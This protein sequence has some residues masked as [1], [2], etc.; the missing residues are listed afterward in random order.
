[1]ARGVLEFSFAR[2]AAGLGGNSAKNANFAKRRGFCGW[3]WIPTFLRR[4]GYRPQR[5]IGLTSTIRGKAAK[6]HFGRR[7]L[8]TKSEGATMKLRGWKPPLAAIALFAAACSSLWTV[9]GAVVGGTLGSLGGPLTAGLGAGAGAAAGENMAQEGRLDDANA[10]ADESE[11]RLTGIFEKMLLASSD[12]VKKAA[13]AAAAEA[14]AKKAKE[15]SGWFV[16]LL[17]TI[18]W[19]VGGIIVLVVV[20]WLL[21][22][23]RGKRNFISSVRKEI[24]EF[25]NGG[26]P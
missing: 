3:I 11:A 17:K 7:A 2:H 20:V 5:A 24:E 4:L 15:Q 21:L 9:G 22:R 26:K 6:N 8:I 16:G 10:R 18:G 14:A 1:M 19:S 23:G 12:E 25:T 13:L